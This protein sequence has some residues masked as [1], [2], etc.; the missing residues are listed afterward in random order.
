MP[1]LDW[2]ADKDLIYHVANI[3]DNADEIVKKSEKGFQKNV[4]DPFSS[5]FQISGFNIDFNTWY[6][7]ELTRQMQKSL[8]NGIGDF[9]Q[10]VLGCVDGWENLGRGKIIDLVCNEKR[11][12]AEVKNKHNTVKGDNLSDL[13]NTLHELVMKKSSRYNGFTAYYVTIIPKKPVRFTK[14][15]TPSDKSVSSRK[16]E[17]Q[18]ILH[19]DG[20][21]FYDL[22]TSSENS[23][24]SL[25]QVLPLVIKK[26]KGNIKIV[27]ETKNLT[28][29]Y[30]DAF[31]KY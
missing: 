24:S 2:I 16:P 26:I 20:A 23:L 25:F 13:Y 6:H 5:L 7:A 19:I 21:S 8:Q 18:E 3:L 12:I 28:K 17:N 14:P 29:Y 27:S 11:I 9:H 1:Y 30:E 10:N 15:F 31:G 4:I 22:V